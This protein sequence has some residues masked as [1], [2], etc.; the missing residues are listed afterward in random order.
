MTDDFRISRLE[1]DVREIKSDLKDLRKEFTDF[2]VEVAKQFGEVAKEFGSIKVWMV[3]TA[4]GMI[5]ST[6]GATAYLV[7]ILKP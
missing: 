3:A 7:H 4:G 2:R 1:E 5:V 6:L